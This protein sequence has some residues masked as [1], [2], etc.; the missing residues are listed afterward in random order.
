MAFQFRKEAIEEELNSTFPSQGQGNPPLYY[1]L[2]ETVVPTYSLNNVAEGTTLPSFLQTAWDFSTGSAAAQNST[3]TAINT[4][5]FWKVNVTGYLNLSAAGSQQVLL[6]ITDGVSV[7]N[8]LQFTD[9]PNGVNDNFIFE[10]QDVYVFVKSGESVV[11]FSSDEARLEANYRQ[12]ATV[13]G[14]LTNPLGFSAA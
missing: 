13:N 12:V 11:L 8:I 7:K 2:S 6:Y 3:V 10:V 9:S 4:T 1:N 5:G 14:V